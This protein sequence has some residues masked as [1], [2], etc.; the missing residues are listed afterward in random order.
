MD[1]LP[2]QTELQRS[3]E[4]SHT[5]Q[6]QPLCVRELLPLPPQRGLEGYGVEGLPH[7]RRCGPAGGSVLA[8]AHVLALDAVQ[9][10][11][12]G[13]GGDGRQGSEYCCQQENQ[14]PGIVTHVYISLFLVILCV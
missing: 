11:P 10:A 2:K 6:H 14:R 13:E 4:L 7:L 12:A 8:V 3:R 9:A 5:A 1:C